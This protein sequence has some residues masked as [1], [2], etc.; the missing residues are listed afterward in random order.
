[1]ASI[2]KLRGFCTKP[3]ASRMKINTNIVFSN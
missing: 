3:K 1:M 2:R